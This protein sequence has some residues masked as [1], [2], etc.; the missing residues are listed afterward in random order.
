MKQYVFSVAFLLAVVI[1]PTAASG[2]VNFTIVSGSCPAGMTCILSLNATNNSHVGQCG[3][4]GVSLCMSNA[5][6]ATLRE[7]TCNSGEVAFLR[8]FQPNDSHVATA[9]SGAYGNISCISGT[10]A[11][12]VAIRNVCH[13]TEVCALSVNSTSNSHVGSCGY[14]GYQICVRE[15]TSVFTFVGRAFDAL[16]GMV[17]G[18]GNLT[19]IVKETGDRAYGVIAGG[20]FTLDLNVS[21]FDPSARR[22]TVGVR[23]NDTSGKSGA[24]QLVVGGGIPTTGNQQCSTNLWRFA[25]TATDI[26]GGERITSGTVTLSVR[27]ASFSNSTTFSGGTWEIY[28][29]PCL[30]SGELYTF[31][32]R[33]TSGGSTGEMAIQQIAK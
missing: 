31:D 5:N 4:Y 18:I 16:T 15:L 21:N 7:T 24:Y 29:N 27:E 13:S 11:F 33:L 32:I 17:V 8:V 6:G 10:R 26:V 2:A 19:A 12:E 30:I 9:E 20:S 3:Y 23:I 25:G 1:S 22:Y 14:Y 28:L